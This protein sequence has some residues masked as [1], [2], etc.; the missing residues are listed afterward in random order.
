MDS[1]LVR[2]TVRCRLPAPQDLRARRGAFHKPHAGPS[3]QALVAAIDFG[4]HSASPWAFRRP[5]DT[6]GFDV[7]R[8]RWAL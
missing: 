3:W 6:D 7:L 1:R 2:R 5:S 8:D 4:Q